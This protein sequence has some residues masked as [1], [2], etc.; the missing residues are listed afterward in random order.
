L[1]D[2]KSLPLS[3]TFPPVQSSI[4]FYREPRAEDLWPRETLNL[5]GSSIEN[6]K[7]ELENHQRRIAMRLMYDG[8]SF[9]GW[10]R[11]PNGRTVQEELEKMLSRL[12]GDNPVGVVGA[13]RT[14]SGVHA[15]GQAAHADIAT[16]YDDA[17]LLHALTRMAPDDIAVARLATVSDRFHARFKACA[18]SYRYMV[19]YRPDPFLARYAWRVDRRLDAALLN[20]AAATFIGEHDFTALSKH[21]PD[22]P[23]MICTVTRSEWIEHDGGIDFHITA[24]RFLYGMVRLLVGL[25]VDIARGGRPAEDVASVLAGRDRAAQSMSAPA[26]GLSLVRVDYPGEYEF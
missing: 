6:P 2:R 10:Q 15:H 7:S 13:G 21:N 9:V 4:T 3:R 18:R 12:A 14:D 23:N 19:I 5:P 11:Q 1:I 25:Q 24:D 8:T 20:E 22:T 16:R 26:H 17:E